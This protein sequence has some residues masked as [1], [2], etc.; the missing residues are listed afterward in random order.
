MGSNFP[1]AQI[2]KLRLGRRMELAWS[3]TNLWQSR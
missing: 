2:G 3:F 1:I